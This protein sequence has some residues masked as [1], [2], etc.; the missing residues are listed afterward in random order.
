M[1]QKFKDMVKTL[2]KPGEAIL[3]QMTAEKCDLMHM[4]CGIVGELI[5]VEQ[6]RWKGDKAN[7]HE[8]LGDT[9]FFLEGLCQIIGHEPKRTESR[10]KHSLGGD[11][12]DLVK[13]VFA[14][15][16]ALK[17]QEIKGDID[18]VYT[19]ICEL[20]EAYKF[21]MDDLEDANIKKLMTKRYPNGYSDQAAA[22]RAD[23]VAT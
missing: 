17:L 1:Q 5:E 15:N 23:K 19:H 20:A 10:I 7:V 14:Y 11:I 2:K 12:L 16:E 8:E 13:K 3:A 9:L 6:G 18:G 22:E 4:G 21:E